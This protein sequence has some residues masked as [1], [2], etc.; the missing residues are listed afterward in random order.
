[1]WKEEKQEKQENRRNGLFYL[2][3]IQESRY[4]WMAGCQLR[5]R[6]MLIRLRLSAFH[7]LSFFLSFLFSEWLSFKTW[8]MMWM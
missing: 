6:R 1:L 8:K 3:N 4:C 5:T 7:F 2:N